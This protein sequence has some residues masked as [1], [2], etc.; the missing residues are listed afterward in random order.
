M[1]NEV[2]LIATRIDSHTQVLDDQVCTLTGIHPEELATG[3][4]WV[5][6]NPQLARAKASHAQSLYHQRYS[7]EIYTSKMRRL[8][9]RVSG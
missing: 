1:A 6:T 9:T 8:M 2:P 4:I 7:R 3:I 5:L